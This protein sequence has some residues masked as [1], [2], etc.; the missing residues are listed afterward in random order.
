MIL[1]VDYGLNFFVLIDE[2]VWYDVVMFFYGMLNMIK[3]I[4]RICY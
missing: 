3:W 2:C 4:E 1:I